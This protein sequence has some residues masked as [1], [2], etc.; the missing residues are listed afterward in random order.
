MNLMIDRR[1]AIALS[2]A[3]L[4]M[5]GCKGAS[6]KHA[7]Q[8]APAVDPEL[9]AIAKE[10]YIYGFP[11]VDSY[12]IQYSYFVDENNPE[13]KGGWNEVHNTARVYTPADKAVQTP[14]SDT[15]YSSIGADLRTE[16]LV[17]SVPEVKPK[18]RYYSAQ[19]IDMYTY[20]IDYIGSRTTG[21][22]AGNFLLA[23]PDWIGDVP[24]GIKKHIRAETQFVFVLFRTQL[25]GP[26]DIGNVKR[27]QAGY[28]V[29]T[30]SQFLH[31]PAPKALPAVD[32]MP[33][34]TAE[35]ERTDVKFFDVLNFVLRFCPVD[36]TE[37]KLL[38]RFR[39]IAIGPDANFEFDSTKL[40]P[41]MK[42]TLE[43]GMADAWKEFAQFKKTQLD[44]G[45][46]A[47]ADGFGTRL[48]LRNNYMLRMASAVLGIYGNSK[49]EA[50]YTGYFADA[51]GEK[52]TGANQYMVRFAPDGLPPVNAFWSLT[53]YELPQSLLVENPLH[54]YLI[55]S[56]MLPE[57][58]KDAD[59]G[60]SLYLQHEAPEGAK[61][62]NWLPAPGGPFLAVLRLYWP[63]EEAVDG[64]WKAPNL[65]KVA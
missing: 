54:R 42:K 13:Y 31:K 23:G 53:M 58:K 45:V 21:N 20:N 46:V 7:A 63:K 16:P 62:S 22:G 57:L 2:G 25:F 10:A 30:L 48:H 52:P 34:L 11:M 27:I 18:E 8:K 15:P 36:P 65:E 64:S 19:F 28:K 6:N 9:R 17:I 51:A 37:N 35:E 29:Q 56:P 60:L 47:S 4:M 32:F 33:P 24:Y 12:R 39:K 14:N 5:A 59:G 50:L 49:E 40:T 38:D 44:T 43:D 26:E 1:R 3:A 55:N 41:A 61:V